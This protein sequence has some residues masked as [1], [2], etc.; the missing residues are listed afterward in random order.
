MKNRRL[1]KISKIKT[2]NTVIRR[3]YLNASREETK[4]QIKIVY[5]AVIGD[6]YRYGEICPPTI[7][8]GPTCDTAHATGLI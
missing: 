3:R 8:S 4:S 5:S 1:H 2:L 6:K 7:L